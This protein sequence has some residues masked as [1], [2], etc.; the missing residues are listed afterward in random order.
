[1]PPP[2]WATLVERLVRVSPRMWAALHLTVTAAPEALSSCSVAVVPGVGD[3]LE[4]LS[5][6]AGGGA[7]L[8]A[9]CQAPARR[10]GCLLWSAR[11]ARPDH[12][13][14]FTFFSK[15]NLLH[16]LS[17]EGPP[18]L[19]CYLLRS[20]SAFKRRGSRRPPSPRAPSDQRL[21]EGRVARA[22]K[23]L[24]HVEDSLYQMCH[25]AHL[26]RLSNTP[27][28]AA[29]LH[30]PGA[31]R[32]GAA[33]E[34]EEGGSELGTVTQT[35]F[36]KRVAPSHGLGSCW[37]HPVGAKWRRVLHLDV[38]GELGGVP[39]LQGASEQPVRLLISI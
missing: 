33:G 4:P 38:R 28:Q 5:P 11:F 35:E 32:G 24:F 14:H 15:Y 12:P 25:S 26:A 21:G 17:M 27:R 10:T 13:S 6:V 2:R 3:K 22:S 31:Q 39:T 19:A 18:T 8:R 30:S 9:T 16:G 29:T 34:F 1:M 37:H 7:A 20:G 36:R 23:T